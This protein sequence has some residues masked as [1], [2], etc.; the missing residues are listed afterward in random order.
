MPLCIHW[1]YFTTHQEQYYR[2]CL[3]Y[4]QNMFECNLHPLSCKDSCEDTVAG[5]IL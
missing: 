2:I 1:Q 4:Q 5:V 3:H